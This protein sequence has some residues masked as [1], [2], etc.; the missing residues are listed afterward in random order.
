MCMVSTVK[1]TWLLMQFSFEGFETIGCQQQHVEH[2]W[3]THV[4]QYM[5]KK[6]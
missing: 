4:V 5:I 3:M 1:T 6:N 2:K